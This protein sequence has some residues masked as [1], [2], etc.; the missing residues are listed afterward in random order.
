MGKKHKKKKIKHI[1]GDAWFEASPEE[2]EAVGIYGVADI[3]DPLAMESAAASLLNSNRKAAA[4]SQDLAP[5]DSALS[6]DVV[7]DEPNAKVKNKRARAF[8]KMSKALAE[9]YRLTVV[10]DQ[11]FKYSE[12]QGCY[13]KV[14]R[15]ERLLDQFLAPDEADQLAKRDC[16][17]IIERVK[18][19][20]YLQ[21]QPDEFNSHPSLINC[22][23]GFIDLAATTTLSATPQP[24]SPA[25]M[26]TYMVNARYIPNWENRD[27]PTFDQFCRTSLE[28]DWVKRQLLLEMIGYICS[29][30]T[31]RKCAFF[32]KGEP[33][34]GKSVISE[35]ICLLSDE[36]L[37]SSVPLHKL[38]ERFNKAE[39]FGKKVNIAGEIKAKKLSEITT[40]KMVT[41][42]DRIL[43]EYK[44]KDPFY[45]SPRCKLL[46]SGN[47]LPGTDEADSTMAFANRLVVLLFNVSI[48]TGE[49]DKELLDKLYAER[50][51]I[52][53]LSVD[54]L[55]QLYH[56]NFQFSTPAD[57]AAFLKAY[58][59]SENS[60][61]AF[62]EDCCVQDPTGRIFNCDL[63]AAY[64]GYC[65]ANGFELRPR[66][67]LYDAIDAIPGVVAQRLR[68]GP[69]N[70]RGRT[71]VRLRSVG[72]TME[73]GAE[74]IVL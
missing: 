71:G 67:Q 56:N 68:I 40:F 12:A 49:Q 74:P 9:C 11:I 39:L 14:V 3:S 6:G 30:F 57:S 59:Y 43:A 54:A 35:F 70:R 4:Q 73:Q 1:F 69:D 63:L 31:A 19:L 42:G 64:S 25:N 27:C 10:G 62:V 53:T 7:E 65:R 28:G 37:V 17:E 66:Q 24:H 5:Q 33:D 21:S 26:F 41:G 32:L 48:P 13:S 23:N 8:S 20:H 44:G 18:R 72:G 51:V 58:R 29:D 38:S 55:R 60:V 46:F 34:S 15:P 2:L 47:A 45:F 36:S 16:E 50:D 52:F 22:K 61:R